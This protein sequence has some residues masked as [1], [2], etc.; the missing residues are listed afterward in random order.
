MTYDF[1]PSCQ[2][3]A[4]HLFEREYQLTPEYMLVGLPTLLALACWRCALGSA[5]C[6]VSVLQYSM[7]FPRG[8]FWAWGPG[9]RIGCWVLEG[10]GLR[11]R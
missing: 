1:R 11:L 10:P 7:V 9:L 2:N 4:L 6:S 3:C 5:S 8:R